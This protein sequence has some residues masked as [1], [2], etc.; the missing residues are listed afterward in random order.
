MLRPVFQLKRRA[1]DTWSVSKLI[2][3]ISCGTLG[4]KHETFP[5]LPCFCDVF[6]KDSQHTDYPNRNDRIN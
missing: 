4:N 6:P 3:S 5:G 2:E 1:N